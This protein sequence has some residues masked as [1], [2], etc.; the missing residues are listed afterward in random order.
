VEDIARAFRVPMPLVNDNRHSTYN[1]V[2]QLLSVWLSGGLGFMIDHVENSL[3]QFFKLPI[4]EVLEFDTDRLLRTDFAGR[5]DGYAKAIQHALMSPNEARAKF[6]GLPP[7]K[8]G[9]KPIVQQQMVPLGW[10]EE[11]AQ[12][13]PEPPPAANEPELTDEEKHGLAVH[14]LQK[15][16]NDG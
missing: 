1:N 5:V 4:T 15:A 14:Y 9:D 3:D 6:S 8:N 11:Q 7:V 2:E 13:P 10:T 12:T 16:M